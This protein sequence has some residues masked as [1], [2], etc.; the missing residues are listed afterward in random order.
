VIERVGDSKAIPVD[1]R[2]I[3]ATNRN[4]SDLVGKG[5]FRKDFYFRINVIPIYLPPLR[6]R[7]QDIPLLAESFFHKMRLKSG[8]SIEGIGN[9]TMEVLMKYSWPGN[10]RELKSAFEYPFVTC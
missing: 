10:V 8:K 2:L 7:A 6:E 4:L 3:S 9:S 5:A 1:A